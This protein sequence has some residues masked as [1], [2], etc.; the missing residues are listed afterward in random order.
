HLPTQHK[1]RKRQK[2][3]SDKSEEEERKRRACESRTRKEQVVHA[4][5]LEEVGEDL[6]RLLDL[7]LDLLGVE[8]LALGR[9]L[10]PLDRQ[11]GVGVEHLLLGLGLG[12]EPLLRQGHDRVLLLLQQPARRLALVT[13]G[14]LVGRGLD[15]LLLVAAAA[16]VVVVL[17]HSRS[18]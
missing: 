4:P 17:L 1:E 3:E 5:L 8:G 15:L 16:V 2:N 9:L 6:E 12:P 10:E 11:L 7:L 18:M 14:P 13:Q